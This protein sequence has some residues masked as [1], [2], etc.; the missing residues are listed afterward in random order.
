MFCVQLRK[1]YNVL[2]FFQVQVLIHFRVGAFIHVPTIWIERRVL[3]KKK[4][5]RWKGGIRNNF[6]CTKSKYYERLEG[7][8]Y[9]PSCESQTATQLQQSPIWMIALEIS[10]RDGAQ[11]QMQNTNLDKFKA[12]E[13]MQWRWILKETQ[14]YPHCLCV[15]LPIGGRGGGC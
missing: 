2:Q 8:D 1:F 13:E 14:S 4:V 9:L 6:L 15:C 10:N 11:S 7:K 5:T 3:K 12:I